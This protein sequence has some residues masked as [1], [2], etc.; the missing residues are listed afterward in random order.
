MFPVAQKLEKAYQ[1]TLTLSK[2]QLLGLA[3]VI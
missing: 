1:H 3:N 2:Y